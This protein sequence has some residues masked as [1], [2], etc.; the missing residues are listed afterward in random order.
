MPRIRNDEIY[1]ATVCTIKDTARR[2]MA[3]EGASALSLRA[4]ARDLELTAP[5]LYRYFPSRD[6]LITAL[7]V[8]AFAAL[9]DALEAA[10]H[11]HDTGDYIEQARQIFIVYRRWA[12]DHP[13]DFALIYGTPIPGYH[14]PSD[15]TVPQVIRGFV[16]MLTALMNAIHHGQAHIPASYTPPPTIV[17]WLRDSIEENHYDG[18]TPEMFYFG[19]NMWTRLHGIIMLELFHH[20]QTP[21]GNVDDYYL[22]EME[23]CLHPLI[24]NP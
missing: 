9:A 11:A 12:L 19:L 6:A 14:A 4:I 17:H 3:A 24:A 22:W 1:D 23:A 18:V 7:I 16:V 15:V 21:V 20:L 2:H 10:A 13:V 5:A 8:D